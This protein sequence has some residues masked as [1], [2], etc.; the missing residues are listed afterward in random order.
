VGQ[1]YGIFDQTSD[2][3]VTRLLAAARAHAGSNPR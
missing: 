1:W 3:E 2:D